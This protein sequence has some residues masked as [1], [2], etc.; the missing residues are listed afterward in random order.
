MYESSR[1]ILFRPNKIVLTVG[2][3]EFRHWSNTFINNLEGKEENQKSTSVT[4]NIF[5]KPTSLTSYNIAKFLNFMILFIHI[6]QVEGL[7]CLN[8]VNG[9]K[10]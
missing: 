9:T 7:Y 6:N 5:V 3:T 4:K 2:H 1:D 8:V 10:Y